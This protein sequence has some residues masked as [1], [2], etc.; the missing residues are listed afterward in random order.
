MWGGGSLKWGSPAPQKRLGLSFFCR[1]LS[2]F[3]GL[4]GL[5]KMTNAL[6]GYT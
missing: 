4:K 2:G 5:S 6:S 1:F 3:R